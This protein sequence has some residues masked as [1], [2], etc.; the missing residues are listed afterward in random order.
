MFSRGWHRGTLGIQKKGKRTQIKKEK[1]SGGAVG[2]ES[3][4]EGGRSGASCTTLRRFSGGGVRRELLNFKVAEED[5]QSGA[6]CRSLRFD[7]RA[8]ERVCTEKEA[9]GETSWF[10]E[11]KRKPNCVSGLDRKGRGKRQR[12]NRLQ[13][14]GS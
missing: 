9:R 12:A 13:A 3:E 8:P 4:K 5:C 7:C 11:G 14:R 1:W 10:N 6:D 2:N